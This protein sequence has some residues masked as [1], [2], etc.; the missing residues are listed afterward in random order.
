MNLSDQNNGNVL[1]HGAHTEGGLENVYPPVAAESGARARNVALADVDLGD[2]LEV[3]AD[4][5][6]PS[7]RLALLEVE[8][9]TLEAVEVVEA[10]V[11]VGSRELLR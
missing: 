5:A 1:K 8:A 11:R 10:D 4:A 9:L 6:D 3:G 2:V 7:Q